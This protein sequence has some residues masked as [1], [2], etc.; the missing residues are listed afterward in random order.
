MFVQVIKGR[1][2]DPEGLQRQAQRWISEVRPD[3][4]GYLG[5]T[6]GVADDGTF[7]VLARFEDESSARAN[8]ERPE[9]QAWWEET[10]GFSDGEPTFRESTD[11]SLLFGG[12][13]DDA[14]FVQV[15]EGRVSDRAK[16]EAWETPE[17]LEELHAARPDLLGA[18]RVLLP[19]GAFV[20]AAYFTSEE[21][22]RRG[23]SS[24]E[25][26]GPQQEYAELFGEMTFIDLRRLQL[27]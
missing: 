8:S 25:F 16:A 24:S 19:D 14:G 18:V 7:V 17:R 26:V 21:A 13:S 12:G 9:Q 23:E 1:T 5:G 22:A 4:I 2:S 6:F 3:A 15:M 11:V 27:S 10:A 20:E